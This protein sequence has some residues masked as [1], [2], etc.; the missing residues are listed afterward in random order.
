VEANVSILSTKGL[1]FRFCVTA[2][3]SAVAADS[4]N[5]AYK[6]AASEAKVEHVNAQHGAYLPLMA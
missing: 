4:V 1:D 2:R 3:P 6:K 5:D